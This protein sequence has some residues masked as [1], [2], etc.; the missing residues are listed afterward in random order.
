CTLPGMGWIDTPLPGAQVGR[1]FEVGGWAFKD[2]V[3][4]ERVEV[5]VDGVPVARA[6]YGREAP[7]VAPFW[8]ISTDPAHPR[9]GYRALVE[10][11]PVPTAPR[12]AGRPV[13]GGMARGG[14]R[15][16]PPF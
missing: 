14:P 13:S 10:L 4:I 11:P 15:R 2:G 16:G 9:V 3:G 12:A 7:H 1:R 5:T 6:E 8:K